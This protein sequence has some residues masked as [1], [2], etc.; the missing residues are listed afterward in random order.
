[1]SF[2]WVTIQCLGQLGPIME[3]MDSVRNPS[4]KLTNQTHKF[5]AVPKGE[6]E[7]LRVGW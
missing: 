7:A 1:M 5:I 4:G 6:H 3:I 2:A